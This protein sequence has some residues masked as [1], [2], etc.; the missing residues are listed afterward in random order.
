ML[1]ALKF[2]SYLV[3]VLSGSQIEAKVFYPEFSSGFQDPLPIEQK[4]FMRF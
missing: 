1:V 2:L 3:I 4:V